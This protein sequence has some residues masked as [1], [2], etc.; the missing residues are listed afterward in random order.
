MRLGFTNCSKV[1]HFS[2]FKPNSL[3]HHNFCVFDINSFH[4]AFLKESSSVCISPRYSTISSV[5]Y[6]VRTEF[7]AHTA[8]YPMRAGGSFPGSRAAGAWNWPL[9]SI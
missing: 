1:N 7:G 8:S 3:T 6:R 2:T 9:T 4:T 5:C